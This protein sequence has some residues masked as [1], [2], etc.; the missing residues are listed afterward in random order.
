MTKPTQE[1]NSEAGRKEMNLTASVEETL[2]QEG[3]SKKKKK[4][5]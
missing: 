1:Y 2:K 4:K 5:N 3:Q